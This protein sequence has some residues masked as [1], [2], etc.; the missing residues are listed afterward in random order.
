M[1][2]YNSNTKMMKIQNFDAVTNEII[3]EHNPNWP[4]ISDH[5]YRISIIGDSRSGKT[6]SLLNLATHQ[7][8]IGR[9]HLYS[10]DPFEANVN[11]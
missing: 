8:D 5:P 1:K 7:P 11:C 4:R 2:Q 3:K 9:N 10:K 6:N